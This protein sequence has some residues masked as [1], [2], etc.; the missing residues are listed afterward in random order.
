MA[1]G[2]IPKVDIDEEKV[3]QIKKNLI[4]INLN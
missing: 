4:L 1:K 3:K 2:K